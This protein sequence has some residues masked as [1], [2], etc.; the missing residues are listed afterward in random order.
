MSLEEDASFWDWPFNHKLLS[1]STAL[2]YGPLMHG[3]FSLYAQT[4]GKGFQPTDAPEFYAK[5]A[6]VGYV[7]NLHWLSIFGKVKKPRLKNYLRATTASVEGIVGS[8]KKDPDLIR[9]GIERFLDATQFLPEEYKWRIEAE[10]QLLR[11]NLEGA[12]EYYTRF[13]DERREQKREL[14]EHL[15]TPVTRILLRAKASLLFLIF[16]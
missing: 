3:I 5:V 10:D 12:L 14:D 7:F 8:L 13:L 16:S 4:Q 11:G 15:A 2:L 1:S 9:Q 6:L